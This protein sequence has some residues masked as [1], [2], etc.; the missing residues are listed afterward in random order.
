MIHRSLFAGLLCFSLSLPTSA[1]I[2]RDARFEILHSVIADQAAAKIGLPFGNEGVDLSESGDI[3]KEKLDRE[4]KKNGQSIAT[5]KVVTITAVSFSDETIEVEVDGGGK[6]KQSFLDRVQVGV[7]MGDKTAPVGRE[8]NTAKARGS[9]IVLRFVKKVPSDLKADQ[10]RQLLNPVLDFNK[11][12]FM[13]TGIES[14]P[15]EF[16][17]GIRA[18]EARIGMDRSTV[19]MAMGR[20][21]NRFYNPGQP[22]YEQWMY[23]LRGL[24]T[25]FVTFED[26][27][28][29]EIKQ[30]DR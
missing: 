14:L 20:P 9:K 1:Q 23:K 11:S 6:N 26:N 25:V 4:L 16:Q 22:N 27:V 3:N 30:F 8:D 24:R 2:T 13:K 5:G 18:K 29:V 10:L 7:G 28:V 12:N 21:N 19:I 15:V 17:E